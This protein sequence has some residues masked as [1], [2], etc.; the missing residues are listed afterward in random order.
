MEKKQQK[1]RRVTPGSHDTFPFTVLVDE[2]IARNLMV[3]TN[4]IANIFFQGGQRAA[5]NMIPPIPLSVILPQFFCLIRLK[6]YSI[7]VGVLPFSIEKRTKFV[8]LSS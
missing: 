6:F 1:W 7:L 8:L 2:D 5:G 3:A 4:S